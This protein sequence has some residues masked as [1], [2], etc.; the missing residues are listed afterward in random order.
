VSKT[1]CW[2]SR[3]GTRPLSIKKIV[4]FGNQELLSK[5]SYQSIVVRSEGLE[6]SIGS[7]HIVP[8]NS[9]GM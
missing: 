6:E 3:S 8:S 1:S 7:L 4:F 9:K 2:V 5:L